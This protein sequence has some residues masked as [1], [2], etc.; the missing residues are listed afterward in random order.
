MAYIEKFAYQKLNRET[1]DGRRLYS[2]PSGD[3]VPSV[4]T[5]L[6]ATKPESAKRA[7]NEWRQKVGVERA[8]AIT[9][10]AA[11]RGTKM[12][13]YLEWY[14]R[15]GATKTLP[16]NPFHRPSWH[17]AD[18]VISKGLANVNEFYGIE[19]PV[20]FPGVYAGTTDC[21][22]RHAGHD[23]IIDFKQT[24]KPKKRE[25]IDDYF[26]QLCAY[27]EAHNEVWHTN[28]KRGVIMMCV[29]PEVDKNYNVVT[30]PQYQEFIIENDEWEHYRSEWW[31]RV[32][33][34][35]NNHG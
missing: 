22:G 18:T 5:I 1:V 27:S 28:I 33:Q 35:Y 21:V 8:Q 31:R 16:D 7:L 4:T 29:K 6:D 3:R 30:P 25:W 24:N 9:T 32:E 13:T 14:I 15:D 20:Y 12:H 17:M 19:V 11:N 26:I 10:E 34:Y 23:S 2:T